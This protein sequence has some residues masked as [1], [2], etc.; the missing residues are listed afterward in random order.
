MT[1][2]MLRSF[3]DSLS[4]VKLNHTCCIDLLVNYTLNF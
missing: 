1:F 3:R 4:A 2:A